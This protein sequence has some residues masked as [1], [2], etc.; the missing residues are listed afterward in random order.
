VL[1]D[2]RSANAIAAAFRLGEDGV[3]LCQPMSSLIG[4]LAT[5]SDIVNGVWVGRLRQVQRHLVA[6]PTST[7]W[8][9]F[10]RM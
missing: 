8:Q 1:G 5:F 2:R 10:E 6:S 4:H 3:Q 9:E 7:I